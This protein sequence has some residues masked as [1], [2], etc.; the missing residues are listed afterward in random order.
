MRNL[1]LDLSIKVCHHFQDGVLSSAVD[2]WQHDVGLEDDGGDAV[3]EQGGEEIL[4]DG[5]ARHA[6]DPEDNTFHVCTKND[7]VR[8]PKG[9]GDP[10][11]T[12]S[13]L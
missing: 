12:I 13:S 1:S 9:S 4:V 3:D 7:M 6:E 11:T 2:V 10:S 5:D 8:S